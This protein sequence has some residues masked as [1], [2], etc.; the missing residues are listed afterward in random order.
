MKPSDERKLVVLTYLIEKG[1][2]T[3]TAIQAELEIAEEED[4]Q[5]GGNL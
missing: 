2:K 1:A 4:F 5:P 3:I